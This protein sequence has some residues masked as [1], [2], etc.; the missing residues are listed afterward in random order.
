MGWPSIGAT[1]PAS[2]SARKWL[3]RV[4]K[5]V[6]PEGP[7]RGERLAGR[8]GEGVSESVGGRREA[9]ASGKGVSAPRV[10][11]RARSRKSR[12]RAATRWALTLPRRLTLADLG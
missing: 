8:V 11:G 2:H 4:G 3:E 5:F 12:T 1:S 6:P 9:E 10:A 7:A